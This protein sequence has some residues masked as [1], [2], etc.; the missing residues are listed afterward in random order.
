MSKINLSRPRFSAHRKSNLVN[1]R[2]FE[3]ENHYSIYI[4][5]K[6]YDIYGFQFYILNSEITSCSGEG[7]VS[8]ENGFSTSFMSSGLVYGVAPT[9]LSKSSNTGLDKYRFLPSHSTVDN[10][11]GLQSKFILLTQIDK[12]NIKIK[13]GKRKLCIT[14]AKI[15]SRSKNGNFIK[16]QA[17]GDCGIVGVDRKS[18]IKVPKISRE[19]M[20]SA[21]N[22][23]NK[24]KSK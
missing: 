9:G 20:L 6:N 7:G 22:K 1:L 4:W 16:L 5:N 24:K 12:K 8:G 15:L 3:T 2:I 11:D 21:Y 17:S 13:D 19:R 10:S 18:S 14:D 23:K